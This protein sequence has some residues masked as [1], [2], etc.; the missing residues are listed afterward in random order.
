MKK[1]CPVSCLC[2]LILVSLLFCSAAAEARISIYPPSLP[3]QLLDDRLAV[4]GVFRIAF[5]RN[6]GWQ[7]IARLPAAKVYREGTAD[8]SPYLNPG[9]AL[10]VRLTPQGGGSAHLDSVL[11]GGRPPEQINRVPEAAELKKLVRTDFDVLPLPGP[12]LELLFPAG[13]T[14]AQLTVTGR[15]EPAEISPEPFR[16]PPANR[17]RRMNGG[18]E[19]YSYRL[20]EEARGSS[21]ESGYGGPAYPWKPLFTE[22]V[23]T[24]SGH[25]AGYTIGR[26]AHD[27]DHLYVTVDFTPDNTRDGE[28]DYCQVHVRAPLGIKTFRITEG[29]PRW[30]RVRFDCDGSVPYQHKIY[31]FKIPWEELGP[32]AVR[33]GGEVL[34]ALSAYGTATPIGEQQPAVAYDSVHHRFLLVYTRYSASPDNFDICG[35][36]IRSD[37][38]LYREEFLITPNPGSYQFYPAV[39]FDPVSRQFLAVWQDNRSGNTDV[40]GQ[41]IGAEGNLAGA[42]FAVADEAPKVE[43]FP[44]LAYDSVNRRFLVVWQGELGVGHYGIYGR[45][46]EASGTFS[47][48][49]FPIQ[50]TADSQRYPAVAFDPAGRRYLVVWQKG[51]LMGDQSVQGLLVESDGSTPALAFNI[52]IDPSY[53]E[54]QPVAALDPVNQRFLV[55]YLKGVTVSGILLKTNGDAAVGEFLIGALPL[56]RAGVGFDDRGE[57]YLAVWDTRNIMGRYEIKGQ[58]L[59]AAGVPEGSGFVIENSINNLAEP[60]LAF[61]PWC[62]N[63]LVV[64]E[65]GGAVYQLGVETVGVA[66]CSNLSLP[67]VLKP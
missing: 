35:K 33:E 13:G 5:F 54:T 39:S 51:A 49:A 47:G 60:V 58:R 59:T 36:I 30:G 22:Y 24:G 11:W 28:A 61:N 9:E 55:A 67:L 32:G 29:D 64:Y 3:P 42:N 40:Y 53:D 8:L 2:P 34:L 6:G 52:A 62:A 38:S 21:P 43:A 27:R 16:F 66:A 1:R 41:W 17:H 56:T 45:L 57:N 48:P 7:E 15:I 18:A 20:G 46:I 10:R 31:E 14:S 37:G 23:L 65:T 26:A 12:G 44:A 4:Q 63:F 19:F 50:V 25:P